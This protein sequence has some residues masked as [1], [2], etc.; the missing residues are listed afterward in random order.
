MV[1]F[2]GT[3]LQCFFVMEEWGKRYMLIKLNVDIANDVFLLS[4]EEKSL[5]KL[6]RKQN[7][8]FRV[9]LI[10]PLAVKLS[11]GRDLKTV[12]GCVSIYPNIRDEYGMK[13]IGNFFICKQ[14]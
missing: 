1:E 8:K 9:T 2:F 14:Y 11:D 4:G 13:D 3:V 6:K 10:S 12:D 5:S 7:I